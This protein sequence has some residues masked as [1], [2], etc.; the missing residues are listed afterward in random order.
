MIRPGAPADT[1]QLREIA[2]AAYMPYV[3]AIGFEPPPLLQD[4]AADI[5][6]SAV[7]VVGDPAAGYIVARPQGEDW[8]IE[9][10]AIAPDAQGQG[11][12][13][14]LIRFAEAEGARRGFARVVLYTNVHM[15]AN[16][17]LYPALGYRE[18]GRTEG[19]G[20]SRVHYEKRLD[21]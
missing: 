14:A 8:L 10:V 4:F 1:D 19:K 3:A 20:L 9:N 2:R 13:G 21:G 18:V 15:T 5:A 7:W 17:T 11:H 6:D 16:L 12:G